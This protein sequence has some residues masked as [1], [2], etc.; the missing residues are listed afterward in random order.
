MLR[1]V[2]CIQESHG[3]PA[4][5]VNSGIGLAIAH[6]VLGKN[7]NVVAVAR[8]EKPLEQLRSQ[9]PKQVRTLVG[10]MADF[11]LAKKAVDLAI[12][13]FGQVDGLVI[14]HG[15]LAPAT[16]IA[17]SV[18][19]DWKHHF[20]VNFFSAVVLVSTTDL[21][22]QLC[23]PPCILNSGRPDLRSE[24]FVKLKGASS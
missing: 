1:E 9:Y 3:R 6:Y 21:R 12:S 16:L 23:L 11:S 15:M 24:I 5:V 22:R 17:D 20:D 14:N 18:V 13:E 2:R 10:D 19:D 4:D 8:S 7:H